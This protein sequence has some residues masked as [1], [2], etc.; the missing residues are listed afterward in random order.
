MRDIIMLLL[1]LFCRSHTGLCRAG[2]FPD[3]CIF[4]LIGALLL[5]IAGPLFLTGTRVL[6]ADIL[7]RLLQL[8]DFGMRGRMCW[9]SIRKPPRMMD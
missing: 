1:T 2:F 3:G 9:T 5:D 7:S 8:S 6:L 4:A